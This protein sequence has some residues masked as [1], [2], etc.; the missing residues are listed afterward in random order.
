MDCVKRELERERP[1]MQT[2]V[3][4]EKDDDGYFAYCPQLK[5][6]HTQG[7]TLDEAMENIREAIEL[8]LEVMSPEEIEAL[9]SKQV[10]TTTVEV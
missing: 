8:H 2:S 4:I 10:F 1:A 5:G 6:C 3:I 9:S 7:D